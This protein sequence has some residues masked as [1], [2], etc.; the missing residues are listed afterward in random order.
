ML[1]LSNLREIY[2]KTSH[3]LKLTGIRSQTFYMDKSGFTDSN[4]EA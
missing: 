4:T 3:M 1:E 2:I